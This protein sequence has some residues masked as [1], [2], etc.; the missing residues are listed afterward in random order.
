MGMYLCMFYVYEPRGG[1]GGWW[2]GVVLLSF[3]EELGTITDVV[4]RFIR[5]YIHRAPR[6]EGGGGGRELNGAV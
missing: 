5:P 1:V 4:R 2:E 3:S 6:L